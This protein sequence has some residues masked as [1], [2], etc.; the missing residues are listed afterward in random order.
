MVTENHHLSLREIATELYVSHKLI[1][2]DCLGM[3]RDEMMLDNA[4]SHKANIVN[5]FLAK[6]STN[7]IEQ[8]LY[9]PDMAPADILLF[10][11]LK[12]PFR[13][14]RFQSIEDIKENRKTHLSWT[15]KID[16]VNK[17]NDRS[18]SNFTSG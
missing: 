2:H 13:G 4:P 3:K 14:T 10:P 7:I 8:P 18:R 9:S 15:D 16:T 1:V 17:L 6:N 11:K 12:W 5:E